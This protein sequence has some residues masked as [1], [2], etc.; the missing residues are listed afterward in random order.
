MDLPF[1]VYQTA[2]MNKL[3]LENDSPV[4][5]FQFGWEAREYAKKLN[6]E[7][8]KPFREADSMRNYYLIFTVVE[9]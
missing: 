5:M 7:M 2:P 4:A 1:K 3:D 8:Y 9:S 6:D